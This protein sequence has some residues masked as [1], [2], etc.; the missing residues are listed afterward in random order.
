[1]SARSAS[2][3]SG[4]RDGAG[5]G[6]AGWW[7]L[8]GVALLAI[9]GM[10]AWLLL[11]DPQPVAPPENPTPTATSV[12][13]ASTSTV[14]TAPS[15]GES[16]EFSP[17][18]EVRDLT[19][20]AF[21]D[22]FHGYQVMGQFGDDVLRSADYSN[23][24]EAKSFSVDVVVG[25]GRFED[26]V[27]GL[28]DPIVLG[29]AVCGTLVGYEDVTSCAMASTDGAM[30]VRSASNTMEVQELARIIQDLYAM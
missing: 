24:K 22:T 28:S 21:P 15:A 6:G 4:R 5:S 17:S 23:N 14:P 1:M 27:D 13:S 26:L 3:P 11:W 10:L 18:H 30:E 16:G 19:T 12:A 8:A 9:L 7:V 20:L 29:D 2:H 25:L